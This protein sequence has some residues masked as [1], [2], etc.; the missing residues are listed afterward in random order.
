[1]SVT[2]CLEEQTDKKHTS[3]SMKLPLLDP[4]EEQL[5]VKRKFPTPSPDT[6]RSLAPFRPG[7]SGGDCDA[8]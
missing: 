4:V 1:M 2:V 6:T 5:K 3:G 8:I 7:P